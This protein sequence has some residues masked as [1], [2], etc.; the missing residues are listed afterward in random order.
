MF[1]S[2]STDSQPSD[3]T[4]DTRCVEPVLDADSRFLYFAFGSNLLR[5]RLQ[6]S[7]PSAI[8][9]GIARLP[10]TTLGFCGWSDRW[11]G[12]VATMFP[13]NQLLRVGVVA[14]SGSEQPLSMNNDASA[15]TT[16]SFADLDSPGLNSAA[17]TILK[18][19][20]DTFD[21]KLNDDAEACTWGVVW[22]I[23]SD[24]LPALDRQE[25]VQEREYCR[26]LSNVDL[27]DVQM[28]TSGAKAMYSQQLGK[29]DIYQ[30]LDRLF[31][32]SCF[33]TDAEEIDAIVQALSAFA[34]P[35]EKALDAL[36]QPGSSRVA[37][38]LT[39]QKVDR[40]LSEIPGIPSNIAVSLPSDS[41]KLVIL[42]GAAQSRLPL[43]YLKRLALLPTNEEQSH[44]VQWKLSYT[45]HDAIAAVCR[46]DAA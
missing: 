20:A 8:F 30:Y 31:T 33:P 9:V 44:Y 10:N 7:A 3:S 17:K 2:A 37:R 11:K 27:Y 19:K 45:A 22:S 15:S 36:L 32:S 23:H 40:P 39:Y 41:Y 24:D 4:T 1:D 21:A 26:T 6:I 43:Y 14:K 34:A 25:G 16:T 18:L 42:R 13:S 29:T 12:G 46:V 5:E 28:L 38:V 35:D